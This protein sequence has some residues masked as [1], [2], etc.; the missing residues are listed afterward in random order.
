MSGVLLRSASY[1]QSAMEGS[2]SRMHEDVRARHFTQTE[3][4]P[5]AALSL[6]VRQR[7][8]CST[9]DMDSDCDMILMPR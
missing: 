8:V 3:C 1:E 5:H 2:K 4:E 9:P 7:F 6:L